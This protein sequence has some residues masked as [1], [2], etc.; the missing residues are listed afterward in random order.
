MKKL[1]LSSMILFLFSTSI[2][3]F[4]VSCQKNA[5]AKI[6]GTTQQNKIVFR[7]ATDVSSEIW[8]ANSDGSNQQRINFSLLLNEKMGE[9]AISPDGTKIFIPT[10][11]KVGNYYRARLYTIDINGNNKTEVIKDSLTGPNTGL[12]IGNVNPF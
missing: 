4:Q 8:I 12:S 9:V 2:M 6:N 5:N 7:R 1:L 3:M 11:E 10:S